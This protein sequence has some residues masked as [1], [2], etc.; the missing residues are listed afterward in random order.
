MGVIAYG[1]NAL[2]RLEEY[3]GADKVSMRK[4]A[5]LSLT[6]TFFL[7]IIPYICGQVLDWMISS[8]EGEGQ[9]DLG[10]ILDVCTLVFL[11]VV[12]WY[13]MTSHSK[14]I[15]SKI[16]LATTKRMRVEMHS[17]I[18]RVPISYIDEMPAGDLSSRFTSDLTAVSKLISTD[19]TGF[20]VHIT[21]VI[22]VLVLMM[23]TSPILGLIYLIMLPL[24]ITIGRWLTDESEEDFA[25]QKEAVSELNSQMSDLITA[26][27][28]IKIENLD[29][30][31]LAKFGQ[32]NDEFTKAFIRS[33]TRSG[34]ISPL[35]SIMS[36][37]GYLI[38]VVL[39]AVLLYNNTIQVGMFLTFMI[40]VRMVNSPLMMTVT[41]FD[42]IR[43]E[44]ISLER[45]LDI[46]QVEDEEVPD[47]DDRFEIP[48]GRA[49]FKDVS[50]SYVKGKEVLH[51]VSFEIR[52]GEITAMVGPTAS[53][54]TTV[55]NLL[56]G[57]YKAD[58]GT[59]E[60]DGQDVR[61]LPRDVLGRSVCAVMQN[62]WI[63]DG[64]IRENVI[65]NRT[66][67][68][69]EDF[70]DVCRITGLDDYV[71][72][73]P[74]GYETMV[75][76]DMKNVPL[77]QRRMI[78]LSRAIIGNPKLL[79]LDEAVAGLD[80]I[81]GQAVFDRLK[82]RIDGRTVLIISHNEALISQADAIID[83]EDGRVVQY[84]ASS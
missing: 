80:P 61:S 26:Q 78:S 54:K 29:E 38:A 55:A 37:S 64:T 72:R 53:G 52:P 8:T 74:D 11:L 1:R 21:M 35:A 17:K 47:P 65:Y 45:I 41:I 50:F 70:Y 84:R 49:T 48:D 76:D 12:V 66:D 25:K 9:I 4:C 32:S 81:T 75:G 15:M 73:L 18:M 68:S 19:Y 40:Y 44:M 79:I 31:V 22:A 33:Q 14:Q 57:F 83:I 6:A 42:E 56:M 63:F 43:S 20:V 69:D 34:M 27:K 3:I 28:T 30:S 62:P 7:Y 67:L 10:T 51:S 5:V 77:A 39:G 46:L 23:F 60:I 16:S 71:R 59:V 24:T 13:V 82:S 2:S 36:N 58:S